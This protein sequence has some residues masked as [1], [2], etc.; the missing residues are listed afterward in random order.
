M[1]QTDMSVASYWITNPTNYLRRN[2]AA[3]GDF[4]GFWYEIKPNPDGPSATSDV[5]PIGNPL[6]ESHDNIA[7]SYKRFGLR[8]FQLA[9]R[10]IPCLPIR[11]D[12][13]SDP[14][15]DN[16]SIESKFYNYLLYKNGES[17]VL[18]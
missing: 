10:T 11:N 16:P 15:S 5:C 14:W 13:N 6:G 7:H 1:L 12:N 17:G 3:G 9:S 18:S 2:R 4:Y 8:I